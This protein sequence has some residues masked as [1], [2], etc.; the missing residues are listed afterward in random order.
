MGAARHLD[1]MS[2]LFPETHTDSIAGTQRKI[3]QILGRRDLEP[4]AH[5]TTTITTR[6]YLRSQAMP[7][8]N[9]K[10]RAIFKAR[11]KPPISA[12]RS[13]VRGTGGAPA[14]SPAKKRRK[15]GMGPQQLR[16]SFVAGQGYVDGAVGPGPKLTPNSRQQLPPVTPVIAAGQSP[17]IYVQPQ[18][19]T[20]GLQIPV[21]VGS[22]LLV[23]LAGEP[24]TVQ[25]ASASGGSG[26]TRPLLRDCNYVIVVG[27][28]EKTRVLR[29]QFLY[30][31]QMV[32]H[33]GA[34]LCQ[35]DAVLLAQAMQ[36]NEVMLSAH[37]VHGGITE[38]CIVSVLSVRYAF[39][40]QPNMWLRRNLGR[41][42]S[43]E[44]ERDGGMLV[45]SGG[46]AVE[47]LPTND[48]DAPLPKCN[49]HMLQL[50]ALDYNTM[51][52][53]PTDTADVV[54]VDNMEVWLHEAKVLLK[55][56]M[57]QKRRVA[58]GVI[59]RG[60]A[61]LDKEVKAQQEHVKK[62]AA[63]LL[64]LE[65]MPTNGARSA[66]QT[67]SAWGNM[68]IDA[69]TRN[70]LLE[71]EHVKLA[72]AAVATHALAGAQRLILALRDRELGGGSD[73]Q[74][75]RVTA[76]GQLMAS[77]LSFCDSKAQMPKK[78]GKLSRFV[79]VKPL[80]M[81]VFN[82]KLTDLLASMP[83]DLLKLCECSFSSKSRSN[84]AILQGFNAPDL[85]LR[86]NFTLKL[87]IREVVASPRFREAVIVPTI[88]EPMAINPKVS[89][90]TRP[91]PPV[92]VYLKDK[93]VGEVFSEMD[94]FLLLTFSLN[95]GA[96]VLQGCPVV[97]AQVGIATAQHSA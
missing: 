48:G 61:M 13:R 38:D 36:S 31:D 7:A 54:S 78:A 68:K 41:F 32:A 10:D 74:G 71:V 2:Q 77:V 45:V 60:P 67:K 65:A 53:P 5:G 94:G 26:K 84:I 6:T 22:A 19:G 82:V 35:P 96:M 29:C 51:P 16:Q 49:G 42:E 87:P 17:R 1:L 80:A 66:S 20:T 23:R 95:E 97:E 28:N 72:G 81:Q 90:G 9:G 47:P 62:M 85:D 63:A 34:A 15:T 21:T 93:N 39:E 55:K 37:P 12:K 8:V 86:G 89:K 91:A 79:H 30:N 58:D 4:A 24:I 70:L 43:D 44:Q 11:E 50:L 64:A 83:V 18:D 56:L 75:D 59:L 88:A 69:A 46:I 92:R 14:D 33:T 27:I 40:Y 25:F 57:A 52:L 76:L 73:A 3:R